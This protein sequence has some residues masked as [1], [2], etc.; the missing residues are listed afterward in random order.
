MWFPVVMSRTR[1]SDLV[2]G[3]VMHGTETLVLYQLVLDWFAPCLL[4]LY[5]IVYF[6]VLCRLSGDKFESIILSNAKYH[7]FGLSKIIC[8]SLFFVLLPISKK[9]KRG[10]RAV[11]PDKGGRGLRQFS[12]RGVWSIWIYKFDFSLSKLLLFFFLL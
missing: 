2:H 5:I 4:V 10:A 8:T 7:Q 3:M 9:K 11:G 1:V 12:M 6:S